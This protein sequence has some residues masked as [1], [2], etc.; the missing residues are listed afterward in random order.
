MKVLALVGLLLTSTV[1]LAE[2]KCE[3]NLK[4]VGIYYTSC[5]VGSLADG[6]DVYHPG[7]SPYPIVRVRCLKPEIV[8][9]EVE[10]NSE[11]I[12]TEE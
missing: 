11:D 10:N 6:V 1:A 7:P 3:I 8:C 12:E 4:S 9:E 2:T 5:P